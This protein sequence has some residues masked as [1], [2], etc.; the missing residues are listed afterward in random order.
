[1]FGKKKRE[2]QEEANRK[3]SEA[4]KKADEA[5]REAREAEEAAGAFAKK[6]KRSLFSRYG[7]QKTEPV[8]P[9]EE[10]PKQEEPA[11]AATATTPAPVPQPAPAQP[12]APIPAAA[13]QP[14]PKQS[15]KARKR[16]E[17]E[18]Q[19]K[20]ARIRELESELKKAEK[21]SKSARFCDFFAFIILLAA[22]LL[23]LL[24]PVLKLILEKTGGVEALTTVSTVAQYC[25]LAAIAI[26]AWYFVYR[27]S[28]GWKIV[29]ALALAGFIVGNILG[30]TL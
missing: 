1:M 18:A 13:A 17:K 4:R 5:E 15:R 12:S 14:A 7:K 11:A 8:A 2:Q 19:K 23:M 16:E 28:I 22:A 29:F 9:A 24:G 20:D 3:A 10:T 6:Q 25:L 26:P 30:L 21:K 27:K